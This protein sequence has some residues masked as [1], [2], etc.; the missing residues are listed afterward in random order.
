MPKLVSPNS[1]KPRRKILKLKGSAYRWDQ[2]VGKSLLLHTCSTSPAN[3]LFLYS[4]SARFL[5]L[6]LICWG[7]LD[8]NGFQIAGDKPNTTPIR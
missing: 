2:L 6:L 8:L 1:R 3:A 4:I 5:L 7:Y